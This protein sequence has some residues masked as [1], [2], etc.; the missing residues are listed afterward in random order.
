M[1]DVG[2]SEPQ[3]VTMDLVGSNTTNQE[4]EQQIN[5]G[6]ATMADIV[7]VSVIPYT[8]VGNNATSSPT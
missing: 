4:Q 6:N 7:F 8:G 3:T 1:I 5:S 2:W